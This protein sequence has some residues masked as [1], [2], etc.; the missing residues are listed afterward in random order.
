MS[1]DSTPPPSV[2]ALRALAA[3]A[4]ASST[5]PT[6]LDDFKPEDFGRPDREDD[7][8]GPFVGTAFFWPWAE[9]IAAVL[10]AAPWLLAQADRC[11]GVEGL[12][13]E[14]YTCLKCCVP[15]DG[16]MRDRIEAAIKGGA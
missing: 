1:H 5:Q 8:L 10:N 16:D 2:E 13:G 6:R 3:A 12:L 14:C 15:L 4:V 11:R 9:Y 7:D